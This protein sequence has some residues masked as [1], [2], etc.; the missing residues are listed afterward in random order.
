MTELVLVGLGGIAGACGLYAVQ[1]RHR[2]PLLPTTVKQAVAGVLARRPY[3]RV[4]PD[5]PPDRTA[6]PL[7]TWHDHAP[8]PASAWPWGH[9]WAPPLEDPPWSTTRT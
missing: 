8:L 4:A 6:P 1:H 2:T 3:Q 7:K 9:T 5:T